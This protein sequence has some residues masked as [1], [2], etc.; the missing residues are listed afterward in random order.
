MPTY[1]VTSPDGK[2]W[3]VSAPDGA[4]QDQVLQYA[5]QQWSA[6]GK[7]PAEPGTKNNNLGAQAGL[8]ARAGLKGALALPAMA[9]D[10]IGGVANAAQDLA[11]GKGR[12]VRFAPT[13][14]AIDDL[15]TRAGVPVPDTPLQKIV[16]KGVEMG[17]GGASGVAS[18]GR[19]ASSAAA[20]PVRAIAARAA[21][22][23]L[24]QITGATGAGLAGQQ[25]KESGAG[26]VAELASS[27]LGSVGGAGGVAGLR[28]AGDAVRNAL[29]RMQQVAI[30]RANQVINVA[31]E[32][33]GIDPAT[34]SPAMRK[35]IQGQVAQAM[36]KGP[37]DDAAVS[38]LADYTIL[39]MTPTRGRLTLDPFDITQEQNIAK[40]AA[41]TGARD[42]KL[43]GIM[44]D[45]NARMLQH[46]ENFNPLNDS[47]T[48]GSRAMA[49]IRAAD[50]AAASAKNQAYRAAEGMAGGD[51]PLQR[52]PL[53]ELYSKLE[54][55]RKTRFVPE[56]VMGTIDDILN[57]T[58][59]PFNVRQLDELKTVIATAQRGTQDGNVKS[60]LK[61]VRDHL[62]AMSLTPEK[63][64]FG[65]GQMVTEQ[66]AKFLRDQDAQAGN[67]KQALDDARGMNFR[68]MRWR[69]SAPAI[70]AAVNDEN[71][72][73]FVQRYIR[74][75]GA[76]A[77]DV[78]RAAQ[79][80]NS[81][82]GARDAV[83]SE[84]VQFLKDRAIGA[85]NQSETGNFSGRGW[86][87]GLASIGPQK[88]RLF[89]EPEEIERL[90]A[91][92]RV[93]TIDTFQPRGSAVNNSNTGAAIGAL[94]KGLS[95]KVAPYAAKV[96]FGKEAITGPLDSWT[97]SVLQRGTMDVPNALL[98]P[99][100]GPR[101]SI[102]DP[103]MLPAVLST[104]ALLAP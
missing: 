74:A 92:G 53:N 70:E 95:D 32:R 10:A 19:V 29:P 25:A 80:I 72:A 38:R 7:A 78:A 82:P 3:E 27:V 102:V 67:I 44:A 24:E 11:L 83:R 13:L 22:N 86:S 84:L 49:P 39:G 14:G 87:A 5:K 88:L 101:G 104:N 58:R 96:P 17:G 20:E 85:G 35:M 36:K 28:A 4:T 51:I 91:L 30:S 63:R 81:D 103:L 54:A 56:Q 23:P 41:A 18:A 64:Q 62:D 8:T 76:D 1:E 61:I 9:A 89:F 47:F 6:Q 65:G 33:G 71:P 21:A 45:N 26:P 48:T 90:A 60:A 75:Q 73:T 2:T 55:A 43:P 59:A 93:G 50:A 98:A 42:A 79:V 100:V 69:E 40:L 34:V 77:R 31:L 66:G 97:L 57:D 68:W 12:G 46:V 16:S 94:I 37:V 15:L 99:R 52:A